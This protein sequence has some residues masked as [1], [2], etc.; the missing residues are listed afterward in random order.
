MSLM[1]IPSNQKTTGVASSDYQTHKK[2]KKNLLICC[3]E[4]HLCQTGAS[5]EFSDQKLQSAYKTTT[6]YVNST[7]HQA[8]QRKYIFRR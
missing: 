6:Q 3:H 5:A 8:E 2:I 1:Q 7:Q 4:T